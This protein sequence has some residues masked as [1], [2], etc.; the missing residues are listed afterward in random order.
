M[1]KILDFQIRRIINKKKSKEF[2][3]LKGISYSTLRQEFRMHLSRFVDDISKFGLDSIKS[4]GASNPGLQNVDRD[5][6]DR[7]AE[8]RNPTS[9]RRYIK[10]SAEDLF[11]DCGRKENGTLNFEP[12]TPEVLYWHIGWGACFLFHGWHQSKIL[13]TLNRSLSSLSVEYDS[14]FA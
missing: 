7:H 13:R 10:L 3:R 2:H 12:L 9:K 8:W 1:K 11:I 6:L 4:G 14:F 5:L